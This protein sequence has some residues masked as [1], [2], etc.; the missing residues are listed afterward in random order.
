MIINAKPKNREIL[1]VRSHVESRGN[2]R[3][4]RLEPSKAGTRLLTS[5]SSSIDGDSAARQGDAPPRRKAKE[6]A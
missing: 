4:V 2:L 3:V 1:I 5:T 6:A